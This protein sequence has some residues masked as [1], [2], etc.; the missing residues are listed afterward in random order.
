MLVVPAATAQRPSAPG[1]TIRGTVVDAETEKTIPSATVA[2]WRAADSTLATGSV[3][4]DNGAFEIRG[5]R[6]GAYYLV[7]SFVGYANQV[8]EDVRISPQSREADLG[9]IALISDTEVLDEIQI[10]AD[11]EPV[12]IQ[13]DRTVYNT[14]DDP[15][16][17]GGTASN[18]LE[19]IPSVDVDIDGNVSLRGSGNVAILINGRS[20]PVGP[21]FLAAYL[22][23]LP[24][25]SIERVEVMPNPS[26]R[27]DPEGMGGIINIVLKDDTDTGLGGTLTASA[28]QRGGYSGTGLVSYGKGPLT[29]AASYGYRRED[30]VAAGQSFRINRYADPL[31]YLDQDED[32][33]ETGTSHLLNLSADYAIAQKTTLTSS[34]Q[35]GIQDE[36]E[37]E[38]NTFLQLDADRAPVLNYLR[39]TREDDSRW[40]ADFRL[41]LQHDFGSPSRRAG[42]GG[43]GGG[44]FRRGRWANRQSGGSSARAGLGSHSLSVE[45]RFSTSNNDGDESYT[46]QLASSG[47]LR[48]RQIAATS[49]DRSDGSLQVDYVRPIGLYRLE[50]GY[51]YDYEGLN[52]DLF[53]QTMDLSTGVFAPDVNLNNTFDYDEN[54]H[55]VYAQVAREWGALGVQFG[56][57]LERASTT[58][59]LINTSESFDNDYVSLFPSAFFTY[60]LNQANTL[61]ASYS[62]RINRPRTWFLNPFP[63]FDDPLNV[64]IG[65]PYLQP[66]YVDAIEAGYVRFMSWG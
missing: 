12:Q 62:R 18:V 32:E 29:L 14:A 17:A 59:T 66:E 42:G 52:S 37:E 61:K 7:V 48:E 53:S 13:I 47:D 20:A 60:K 36:V 25:S 50:A 39:L 45:A 40:D 54:I 9:A 33:D 11:R 38:L 1:G 55:A 57:R 43:D 23:Q 30:D 3:T 27:F 10:A 34:A 4:D 56:A 2:V 22:R 26:A 65:N 51:D 8:V 21:E 6:G 28:D 46:E 58:F 15:M 41:G 49:R 35:F 63:S 19:T 64:R 16:A 31:T 44:G 5:V 24:A